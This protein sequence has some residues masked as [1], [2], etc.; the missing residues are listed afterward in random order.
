[1]ENLFTPPSALKLDGSNLEQAWKFWTQKLDLYMTASGADQK[2]ESTQLAIFLHLI[3]DEALQ[4]YNTFTFASAD[5]RN[6]LAT[7]RQRFADYCTPRRNIVYERYEF[8]RQTQAPG[9]N[10]DTFVTSLRL[11]AKTCDFGTQEESMIRDRIVLGCPDQRLQERLLREPDLTLTKALT[12]C[13]A[14]EATK[15]QLRVIAG[16]TSATSVHQIESGR[17][18]STR[19]SH[20]RGRRPGRSEVDHS[21]PEGQS[22]CG[23]CGRSHPPKSCPAYKQVCK[24]CGK[25][26]HW[27]KLCRSSR[28][29]SPS[30]GAHGH[31]SN[32]VPASST[33]PSSAVHAVQENLESMFVGYLCIDACEEV[34]QSCWW[35]LFSINHTSV[36]CKLDT[37]AEA[38]VMSRAAFESLMQ[39]ATLR[40]ATS[41]L[42]A[43]GNTKL[44]PLGVAS[45]TLEHA[46]KPWPVDFFVVDVPAPT[47]VGLPTCTMLDVVRRIDAVHS[48]SGQ[49]LS[50]LEEY[51]DVFE[52]LGEM[53]G[54]YHIEL[55]E[56]VTP[57]VHAPRKVPLALQPRLK[58]ALDDMEQKGVIKKCD[59]PTDWVSSLLIVE[60]KNGSLLLCLD[61]RDL[62]KAVKREHFVLP[63]CEDVLA[64]L[65]GK[66]IFT[67][68]D[69][70][71][72]FWQVKLDEA[73]SKLCTFNT[74][75]GRYSMR[76]L[77]FGLSSSPEVFQKR[78]MENFGDIPNAHVVFDDMIVAA[79]NEAEHEATLR[80]VLNRAREKNVKFN[81][82]K[83]QYKVSQVRFLGHLL[84]G[85]GCSPDDEKV[86]AIRGMPV[87][88]SRP[89]L[90][91][92][93]GMITY[94]SK[95]IPHFSQHTEP[96]RQL[97]RKNVDWQWGPEHDDAIAR[98]KVLLQSAPTLAYFDPADDAWI[99][100]D[101][102][103][104]GLGACL[105]QRGRPI[106]FASRALTEAE[107]NYAQ[108]EKELL[109]IVFACEKFAQY[110]YGRL[111]VVQSDHKPLETIFKKQI[112]AT[113]PR[114]QRML[115]R[116]MKYS[117]RI[118]YVPG[119]KMFIADTLSR[120]YLPHK[121]TDADRELA[122]DIDVTVHS[123]V[124]SYPASEH[125]LR[126]LREAT[127]S[128]PVLSVVRQYI[129]DGVLD[130]TTPPLP[131]VKLLMKSVAEMCE[132]D[133]LL[134]LNG[135][136]VIPQAMRKTIL[137]TAHEGHLGIEKTKQLARTSVYWPGLS[138]DIERLVSK[139]HVCQSFQRAQQREPL[140]PH[141]VPERPWQKVSADIFTLDRKDYL[142]VI[143]Y[144]SHFPEIALLENKTAPCVIIHLK[145]L[146]A[147]YGIPDVLMGDNMPFNSKACHDFA[148]DWN[149]D[150]VWSSPR[151]SQSNGMVE[152]AVQ[153]VKT[154]LKKA[155]EDGKDPYIALLQHRCA[156]LSG[157][158]VSPAQLLMNR[159]LRTKLP[160]SLD[161][162]QSRLTYFTQSIARPLCDSR[163][164]CIHESASY[165]RVCVTL[166]A[167]LHTIRC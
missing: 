67:I 90:Q 131:E 95:F 68:I 124:A 166:R 23:N 97:L 22:S 154:L 4:V 135:K 28:R 55:D 117:L 83:V 140:M 86:A 132:L 121:P 17:G 114:L 105:L 48:P 46:G 31:R 104:R 8:W 85:Y 119:S 38:N 106:A 161:Q 129:R 81:R 69:L 10:I 130:D 94:V 157:S 127:D 96:L 73:S 16:A 54:Q 70:R 88:Q 148:K 110:I 76:R 65:H 146:F 13:R 153:T 60:K 71:D 144:Y 99:Q 136:L 57:V 9:E 41:V 116:L 112:S 35:K 160:T 30:R 125:R 139:C 75:F 123:V 141:P 44:R 164:T 37:G 115:L 59:A 152:R 163:V 126:E 26:G 149:F 11:K 155:K 128:D 151:F 52:G 109:A 27:A 138:R 19:R 101:A 122:E 113:T 120:A 47:I 14:A 56:S 79:A 6:N 39:P 58:A 66:S 7:V 89:E 92:F 142:L 98:L 111:T 134:F 145:S 167:K 24:A 91:R 107:C 40:P 1:M 43:Y 33:A 158:T 72:G 50:P 77:P 147:R 84:S 12:I 64:K 62:N 29:R 162:F 5:D 80:A 51:A 137:D 87:P 21:R 78:N 159:T 34:S 103:S 156:P 2:P 20:S 3:G 108:I 61:P 42:T 118:E 100:T 15:E 93:L 36:R 49:S 82:T 53:P 150:L 133:G 32:F 102:S 18:T 74:P 143:D 45:L 25:E 63:T 165:I